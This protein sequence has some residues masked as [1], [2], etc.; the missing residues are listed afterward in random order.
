MFRLKHKHTNNKID[1][2]PPANAARLLAQQSLARALFG[3]IAV[4]MLLCWGWAVMSFTSGRVYPWATILMGGLIGIAT[5][6]FGRGLSWRFPVI[7][8]VVAGLAAYAG[9]LMIGVLQTGQYIG[10]HPVQVIAGLSSDTF[11]YFFKNTISPITHIYAFCAAGVAAFF[12]N[13]R[14]NRRQVLALRTLAKEQ[15]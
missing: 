9:N 14:L 12:A 2:F 8:A 5:Q 15:E 10:A 3:A 7:A 4:A 1:K 6:R 11:D 13:R